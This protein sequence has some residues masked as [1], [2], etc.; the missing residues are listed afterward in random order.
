M[1]VADYNEYSE[2]ERNF[3]KNL[4]FFLFPWLQGGSSVECKPDV[5]V[6]LE[7]SVAVGS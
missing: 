7:A 2:G 5:S 6:A 4:F 1:F 3:V